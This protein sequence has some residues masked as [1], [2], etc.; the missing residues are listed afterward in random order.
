MCIRDRSAVGKI[1]VG[2]ES[3]VQAGAI[4]LVD[5]VVTTGKAKYEALEKIRLLGDH[6]IAGM[7]VAVDRQELLGDADEVGQLSAI[8]ALEKELGNGEPSEQ[9]QVRLT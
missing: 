8:Q 5:D 6:T 2:A 3:F 9:S 1:I 7:V 4:L